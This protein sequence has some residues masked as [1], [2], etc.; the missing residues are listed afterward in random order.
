MIS[1]NYLTFHSATSSKQKKN[2]IN[3][4][5]S[6]VCVNC[7]WLLIIVTVMHEI[8]LKSLFYRWKWINWAITW[9][10]LISRLVKF[11]TILFSLLRCYGLRTIFR[12]KF[13]NWL[14][15]LKSFTWFWFKCEFRVCLDMKLTSKDGWL[16]CWLC[17]TVIFLSL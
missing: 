17:D 8:C 13:F 10:I 16:Y 6:N 15:L 5:L 9:H 14:N 1:P 12:N 2:W 11:N 3:Y 7:Y 4:L